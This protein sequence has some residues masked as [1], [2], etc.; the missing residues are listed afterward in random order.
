MNNSGFLIAKFL[1][2]WVLVYHCIVYGKVSI[3]IPQLAFQ[4]C[5]HIIPANA[6]T[7]TIFSDLSF[8]NYYKTNM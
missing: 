1:C 7:I 8:I 4:F 2:I 6:F 3:L 5:L